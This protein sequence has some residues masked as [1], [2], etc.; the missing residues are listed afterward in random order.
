[1][2]S[3]RWKRSGFLPELQE[4]SWQRLAEH[5][6]RH[7]AALVAVGEARE[8][9]DEGA[10][11][12]AILTLC[13]VTA[14]AISDLTEHVGEADQAYSAARATVMPAKP[15]TPP[16]RPNAVLLESFEREAEEARQREREHLA[17]TGPKRVRLREDW[18]VLK[19]FVGRTLT[20]DML[21]GGR[22]VP[23]II[24]EVERERERVGGV[25][26]A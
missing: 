17:S 19:Q 24:L 26:A 21:A 5:R 2:R 13:D 23:G 14:A 7:E 20:A 16:A 15:P 1:M 11:A 12:K 6:E 10:E 22:I 25:A 18:E 9:G 3:A 4:V 8:A